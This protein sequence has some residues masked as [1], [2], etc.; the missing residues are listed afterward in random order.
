VNNTA[1]NT[2]L[3]VPS[4]VSLSTNQYVVLGVGD[5]LSPSEFTAAGAAITYYLLATV[6]VPVIYLPNGTE[7]YN[8]LN[9]LTQGDS[10]TFAITHVH[11]YWWTYTYAGKDITGSSSWENGTY[12]LG[13]SMASGTLCEEGA[14]VG[15]SFVTLLY[16]ASGAATPSIPLTSVPW[17]IGIGSSGAAPQ[18]ANV[19]P[20][21]NAT[22]GVVGIQSHAQ[23]ASIGINH[24]RVGSSPTVPYP[25]EFV[26]AWGN[27]KII[28]LNTSKLS[29]ITASLAYNG[30]QWFNATAINQN[31]APVPGAKITWAISPATLG[32]LNVNTGPTVI[33]TAGD[34]TSSGKLWAN[35]SFNCSTISD[36][37][38]IT[39][40]KTGGPTIESFAASPTPILLGGTTMLNVTNDTWQHP[41]IYHYSGLPAGCVS[42]NV[43]SLSCHPSSAGNY[44][45][46]VYLNDSLMHSSNAATNLLVYPDLATPTFKITPG[47]LT[48]NTTMT[49]NVSAVGGFPPLTYEFTGLPAGCPD[50]R[51][52]ASFTCV[53]TSWGNFTP[54]VFVN[55]SESHS[56]SATSKVVVNVELSVAAFTASP[57]TIPF[58]GTTYLNVTASGGTPPY[59]YSYSYLPAGCVSANTASLA[60]SPTNNGSFLPEVNITDSSGYNAS[61]FTPFFVEAPTVL[62]ISAFAATP[63]TVTVGN[64]TNITATVSGGSTPYTYVYTG[65][66]TGCSG[67]NGPSFACIPTAAGNFTLNLTVTDAKGH[68]AYHTASLMVN[69]APTSLAITSFG[70]SPGTVTLGSGTTLTVVA[71]GGKTPYTYT[72]TGLPAGCS[73]TDTSALTCTPTANGTFTIRVFV[74]DSAGHSRSDTTTLTV[75]SGN[76]SSSSGSSTT[77]LLVI[78]VVVVV[79]VVAVVAVVMLRKKKQAQSVPPPA[80]Y[81][82]PPPQ[83]YMAPPPQQGPPQGPPP[84]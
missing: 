53:P 57:S 1:L 37:A 55:D 39:V 5:P 19:M 17:A 58:G 62:T 21:F 83:Q 56:A 82:Q 61:G 66:P 35:V 68:N 25:G 4:G 27:Y 69:P 74:N 29:P 45:V 67:P 11:G 76:G 48:M 23:V 26:P 14:T 84:R 41:I 36:V 33:L 28:I 63:A 77:L 60:C 51:Q 16:G 79:V 31:G 44:T 8:A 70:A 30:T 49:I 71:T 54:R 18:A 10:Y 78:V 72:Y 73:S 2:T 81:A 22:L 7:V 43:S 13:V 64:S 65:L 3:Y 59:K 47:A 40:T 42:A 20:Q 50:G 32:N 6:A 38:S 80:Y 12:N 75:N 46:R 52:P 24:L 15:P 34:V 9:T